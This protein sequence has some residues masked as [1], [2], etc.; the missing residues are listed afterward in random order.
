MLSPHKVARIF[1]A[2]AVLASLTGAAKVK[3]DPANPTC[4][5]NPDWSANATMLLTPVKK[6][7]AKVLLA[8]GRIDAGLPDRLKAALAANPDVS[9]IWLR[10]PGGDA[11]AGNAAGRIIRSNFGLVT[12]IPSGWA[13]FSACNFVFM[14]GQ[15]RVI[16]PGGLFI[17]HMFTRTGDRGAIDMSVA[18]GTDA[19]KE[20]I[21]DIE[22]DAALLASE[23][24]D[25]L[26]RMGV[27][28]KLLTEVMYQQKALANAEDKS[29]R[30]C[31]TLAE[32]KTY[33]V[34]NN[35]E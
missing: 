15:P 31:L 5:A 35:N 11:R 12:R 26:I 17:V 34:A 10:S 32:V 24:N 25:F 29:T 13:C 14:G 6:G 2:A 28:R 23:D 20:L 16:D 21:G 27:S 8:E 4:P 30:R 3:M 19:T 22:Q 1:L 9:E 33:N 18:M 7:D